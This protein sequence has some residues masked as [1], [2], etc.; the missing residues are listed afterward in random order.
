MHT[1]VPQCRARRSATK[2]RRAAN[3]DTRCAAR[4]AFAANTAP[5]KL[6]ASASALAL[7]LAAFAAPAAFGDTAETDP[8][9]RVRE[10]EARIAKLEKRQVMTDADDAKAA[11]STPQVSLGTGGLNIAVPDKSFNVKIGA[12]VQAD[13]RFW[14]DSPA[15]FNDTFMMRRVRLPIAGTFGDFVKFNLTPSFDAADA[16]PTVSVSEA[17]NGTHTATVSNS[18]NTQLF[19]A[20]IEARFMKEFG[21]TFGKFR[22]PVALTGPDNRHFSEAPFTNHLA[23]NRDIGVDASGS[24]FGGVLGYRLGLYDGA[25]NNT[26]N[27]TVNAD[28]HFSGAG[29]LTLSPFI[30]SGYDALA[31]LVFS[32][33]ASYGSES[34]NSAA[35]KSVSTQNISGAFAMRGDHVR[36]A[37]AVQWYWGPLSVVGEFAYDRPTRASD[38]AHIVNTAWTVA[39]GFVLTGEKSTPRGVT[40]DTPFNIGAWHFG[41]VELVARVGGVDI[42]SKLAANSTASSAFAVGV[43]VNWYLT[44]NLLVRTG[45]ELTDYNAST[46]APSA[47]IKDGEITCFT[48]VE[49]K[50]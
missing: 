10:L 24:F 38:H 27:A 47:L 33:G 7:L 34:G 19:E 14:L 43:G 32:I 21:L 11:A 44:K 9:T 23:P 42:D 25:P 37:P 13:G 1:T 50:F 16:A 29:R 35:V 49:L 2:L 45:V 41:A 39:A 36:F 4:R 8:Q 5:A 15:T 26:Y 31:G 22:S 12:L 28:T 17:A 18:N 30:G 3:S 48:R 6:G 20:W 46:A 40:P